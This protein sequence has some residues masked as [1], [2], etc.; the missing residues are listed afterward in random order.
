MPL[1]GAEG[2]NFLHSPVRAMFL[3]LLINR[4]RRAKEGEGTDSIEG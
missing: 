2:V 3:G 4:K 1:I